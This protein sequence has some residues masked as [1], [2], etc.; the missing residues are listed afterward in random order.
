M[1]EASTTQ[2][3]EDHP[4]YGWIVDAQRFAS[5]KAKLWKLLDERGKFRLAREHAMEAEELGL[6]DYH[7][8]QYEPLEGKL[9]T[10]NCLRADPAEPDLLDWLEGLRAFEGAPPTS[11]TPE[12][13]SLETRSGESQPGLVQPSEVASSGP[14]DR[15]A[16]AGRTASTV[17]P[18]STDGTQAG[19]VT[20]PE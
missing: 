15:G 13:E 17:N 4:E 16:P 7:S 12:T 11:S 6:A 10:E 19:G 5:A 9:D 1:S 2:R 18:S 3:L 14:A 20:T 8:L